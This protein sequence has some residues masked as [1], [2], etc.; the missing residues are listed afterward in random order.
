MEFLIEPLE[1]GSEFDDAIACVVYCGAGCIWKG[2]T[3]TPPPPP[4]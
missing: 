2:P 3:P 4:G 1:P